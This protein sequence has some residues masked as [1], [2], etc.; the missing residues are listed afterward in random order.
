[1]SSAIG[2]ARSDPGAG[3]GTG[4]RSNGG[5]SRIDNLTIWNSTVEFSNS[6]TGAG[7]GTG[8]RGNEGSEGP[9]ANCSI[10]SLLISESY[11]N[12]C[13]SQNGAGIG[14]GYL[15]EGGTSTIER[16]AIV[17][18]TVVEVVSQSDGPGIGATAGSCS[19]AAIGVLL[20]AR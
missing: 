18:S 20:I 17:N 7:I 11:I 3:I 8:G 9:G 2:E 6:L 14:T 19:S 4:P 13:R 5:N 1:L 12:E 15:Y 10:G 16:L